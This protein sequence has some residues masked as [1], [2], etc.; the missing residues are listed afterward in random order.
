MIGDDVSDGELAV[1]DPR[2][3]ADLGHV[4]A[5]EH[6]DPAGERQQRERPQRER[7]GS[8]RPRST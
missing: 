1:D 5:R 6:G 7:A 2:L 4:P 3:A 8:A